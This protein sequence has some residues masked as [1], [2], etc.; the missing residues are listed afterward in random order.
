MTTTT[1]TS[2][3]TAA[4]HPYG[5]PHARHDAQDWWVSAFRGLILTFSGFVFL[6]P[7]LDVAGGGLVFASMAIMGGGI[8]IINAR[9]LRS[10]VIALQGLT[11]FTLGVIAVVLAEGSGRLLLACASTWAIT[12]GAFDIFLAQRHKLLRGRQLFRLGGL[13]AITGGLFLAWAAFDPRVP[14]L[15]VL[16]ATSFAYGVCL[17]LAGIRRSRRHGH[18]AAATSSHR[19]AVSRR[20]ERSEWA[21]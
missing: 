4:A 3:P 20:P 18:V 16:S 8:Q 9:D 5:I 17:I 14:W 13:L 6:V 7:G 10:I 12:M 21:D 2:S 19:D 1:T 15:Y 11:A